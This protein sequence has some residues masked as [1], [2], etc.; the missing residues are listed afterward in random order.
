M[1]GFLELVEGGVEGRTGL[2]NV[3]SS[4]VGPFAP[5]GVR[6]FGVVSMPGSRQGLRVQTPIYMQG[7]EGDIP[8]RP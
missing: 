6:R 7:Q 3:A 2:K 1:E 8:G 5:S 4:F